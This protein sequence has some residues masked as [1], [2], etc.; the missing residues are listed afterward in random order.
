MS[1]EKTPEL[2]KAAEVHWARKTEEWL[3]AAKPDSNNITHGM[4]DHAQCAAR[5]G[6]GEVL[7]EVLTRLACRKYLFPSM[8]MSYWPGQNGFGFDPVGTLPE[9]VHNGLIFSLDG[10]VD[11]LPALPKDWP[12]GELRGTRARGQLRIDRLAWDVAAGKLQLELT[13]GRD[14]TLALRPPRAI[15]VKES[16]VSEDAT[17]QPR[18]D[19]GFDLT[20]QANRKAVVELK[21]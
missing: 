20:L 2:W 14:Q 11:L 16:R 5:L 1:P 18:S 21:W 19:G 7:H 10:Q 17:L 15:K 6:Q 13:S 4:I 8:M 9:V 12:K 3:R